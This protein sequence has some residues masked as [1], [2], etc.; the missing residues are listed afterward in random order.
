MLYLFGLFI[1]NLE[2]QEQ[3]YAFR[4]HCTVGSQKHTAAVQLAWLTWA[5]VTGIDLHKKPHFR[6]YWRICQTSLLLILQYYRLLRAS[7]I[8]RNGDHRPT[9]LAIISPA[10]NSSTC[11]MDDINTL[12]IKILL[13]PHDCFSSFHWWAIGVLGQC[14]WRNVASHVCQLL[15]FKNIVLPA[16]FTARLTADWHWYTD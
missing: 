15:N 2:N 6:F 7:H 1:R 3:S 10:Q 12:I 5:E 14:I 11:C 16:F 4:K 8:W 9:V 13:L